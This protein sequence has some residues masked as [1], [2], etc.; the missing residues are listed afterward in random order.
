MTNAARKSVPE[1]RG[2][3]VREPAAVARVAST[4]AA[5]RR[6]QG[7]IGNRAATTLLRGGSFTAGGGA[8]GEAASRTLARDPDP[9]ALA[10]E[11]KQIAQELNLRTSLIAYAWLCTTA[12]DGYRDWMVEKLVTGLISVYIPE[13]RAEVAHVDYQSA[14]AG[15]S[16]KAAAGTI[17]FGDEALWRVALGAIDKVGE[18][19][20]GAARDLAAV[21]FKA[22]QPA[23]VWIGGERVQVSSE[24]EAKDAERIIRLLTE[25]YGVAFD[26]VATRR[27]ARLDKAQR[28]ASTERVQA[29]DVVPWTYMD[30]RDLEQG[31]KYYAAVLGK[32]R[33]KSTRAS[34][35]QEVVRIGRLS[36]D[37][38]HEPGAQPEEAEY[39]TDS[40]TIAVY[41]AHS[42]VIADP[43]ES[44]IV[45]EIAHAVFGPLVDKFRTDIGYWPEVSA[46]RGNPSFEAPPTHYGDKNPDEDIAESVALFFTAPDSLK[47]GIRGHKPGEWGNPCPKRYAWIERVVAGWSHK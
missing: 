33:S 10:V 25:T 20:R 3:Q 8:A 15:V 26:S 21:D 2:D 41:H 30:L 19:L 17:V 46:H 44:T 1:G 22:G 40:K 31:F 23:V 38:M 24:A 36:T 29:S 13:S 43:D 7:A 28:G 9:Q 5:I 6:L 16:A 14:A 11:D 4:P 39:L 42:R 37:A 34:T 35:P 32:T 45:H 27:A 12:P 47:R 18:E